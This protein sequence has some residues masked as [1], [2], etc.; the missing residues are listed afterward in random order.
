[1]MKND[2]LE[3]LNV[4][5]YIKVADE[6]LNSM[7][8]T[9]HNIAHVSR[10]AKMACKLLE[11]LGYDGHILKLTEI[12]G[13]MHDIG[14]LINRNGHAHFGALLAHD[15]LLKAGYPI[16]DVLIIMSAI[17][18]HDEGTG[19]PV[20]V[21][22][23]ALILADKADV[24]RSRVRRLNVAEFDIHDRVNYAV[25]S[26]WLEVDKDNCVIKLNLSLD[27]TYSSV[28]DYCSIFSTRMEFCRKAAKTLG[29]NFC[30]NINGILLMD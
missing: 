4:L 1:M 23:A 21:V 7:Q 25:S 8:Y 22:S 14:N 10:V 12:A 28:L 20:N 13:Y 15:L 9:E 24:R 16:E 11:D 5:E 19:Y 30:L 3:K 26:S 17:G 2:E 6:C 27:S 29:M 18:N